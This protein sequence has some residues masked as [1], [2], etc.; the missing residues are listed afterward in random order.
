MNTHT[1]QRVDHNGLKSFMIEKSLISFTFGLLQLFK[2]SS[3]GLFDAIVQV[4][5]RSV[6]YLSV[7]DEN[8][9]LSFFEN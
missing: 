2:N 8:F 1:E 7:A 9:V 6:S 3:Q 4:Y 5:L